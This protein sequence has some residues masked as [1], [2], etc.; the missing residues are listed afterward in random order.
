MVKGEVKV[1][2]EIGRRRVRGLLYMEKLK[3]GCGMAEKS[4]GEL[5]RR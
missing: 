5:S 4:G 3:E 2:G 1:L